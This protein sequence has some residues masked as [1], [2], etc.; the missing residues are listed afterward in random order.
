MAEEKVIGQCALCQQPRELR[1]SHFLPAALYRLVRAANKPKPEPILTT[2]AGQQHTSHQ[3]WQHLL[4]CDCEGK[5]NRNGE[6]WVLSHCYRG[7]GRFR[8]RD[9]VERCKPY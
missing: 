9:I 3:A 4:C 7:R 1:R 2:A 8:L 6:N 5:F